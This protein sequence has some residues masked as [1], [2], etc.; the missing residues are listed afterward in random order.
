VAFLYATG[1]GFLLFAWRADF[2]G[3]TGLALALFGLV[4][5]PLTG[6]LTGAVYP[7]IPIVGA[8]CP[9]VI[10][11]FGLLLLT[12]T[13]VPLPLLAIPFLWAVGA[14][15]PIAAGMWSDLVLL[16]GGVLASTMIMYR[17]NQLAK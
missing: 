4:L 10:F 3:L 17:N 13:R 11:T 7:Q 2:Y 5:Y 6:Y 14:V 9:A 1:R 16:V 15:V 12:T 8:P